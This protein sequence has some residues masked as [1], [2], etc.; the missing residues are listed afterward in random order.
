MALVNSMHTRVKHAYRV[1]LFLLADVT[2]FGNNSY[3]EKLN[4]PRIGVTFSMKDNGVKSVVSTK[5]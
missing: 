4:E 2:L 3:T 1:T 5:L